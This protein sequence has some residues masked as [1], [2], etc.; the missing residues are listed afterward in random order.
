MK[1]IIWRAFHRTICLT[2]PSLA[3]NNWPQTVQ[4]NSLITRPLRQEK[5]KKLNDTIVVFPIYMTSIWHYVLQQTYYLSMT[6]RLVSDLSS[7]P[8]FTASTLSSMPVLPIDLLAQRSLLRRRASRCFTQLAT[9]SLEDWLLHLLVLWLSDFNSSG[10]DRSS[11]P[12]SPLKRTMLRERKER[13]F[14]VTYMHQ[15][16]SLSGTKWKWSMVEILATFTAKIQ[17]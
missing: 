1:K 8:T 14:W 12:L 4:R 9:R 10:L 13:F 15:E 2:R 16:T 5:K 17:P 3:P 11:L 7:N 6:F